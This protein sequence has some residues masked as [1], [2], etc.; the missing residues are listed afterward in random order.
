M[1]WVDNGGVDINWD[2]SPVSSLVTQRV[3]AG[4]IRK[5]SWRIQQALTIKLK[6]LTCHLCSV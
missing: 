3:E 2:V 5:C 6:G 4:T 1:G